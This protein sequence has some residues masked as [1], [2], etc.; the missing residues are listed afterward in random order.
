MRGG[1]CGKGRVVGCSGGSGFFFCVFPSI[2]LYSVMRRRSVEKQ[3][4]TNKHTKKALFC[5]EVREMKKT[6]ERQDK[7]SKHVPPKN[8]SLSEIF[9]LCFLFGRSLCWPTFLFYV[10]HASHVQT[11]APAS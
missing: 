6:K 7:A 4:S 11:T 2:I 1:V 5:G 8:F 9:G 10:R 3:G